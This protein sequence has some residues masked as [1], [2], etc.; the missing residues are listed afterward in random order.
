[1]LQQGRSNLSVE[2]R[3]VVDGSVSSQIASQKSERRSGCTK[4][5]KLIAKGRAETAVMVAG[6]ALTMR[7][8]SVCRQL[9]VRSTA[10]RL[11]VRCLVDME[12]KMLRIRKHRVLQA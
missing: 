10:T 9:V 1:M 3:S 6:V 11:D 8:S 7:D 12:L 4:G 5:L 2:S